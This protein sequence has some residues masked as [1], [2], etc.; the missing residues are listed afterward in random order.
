M[1][2]TTCN[3]RADRVAI[4]VIRDST[5]PQKE[6]ANVKFDALAAQAMIS[7]FIKQARAPNDDVERSL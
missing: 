5:V 7:F 6:Q 4:E 1:L 3:F 2:S